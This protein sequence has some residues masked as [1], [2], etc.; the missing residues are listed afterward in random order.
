VTACFGHL[1]VY[2]KFVSGFV[3]TKKKSGP[4][5]IVPGASTQATAASTA[6]PAAGDSKQAGTQ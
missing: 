4:I 2:D 6:A 5:L 1:Q 3:K